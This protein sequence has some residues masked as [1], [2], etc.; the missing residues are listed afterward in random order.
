MTP[1]PLIF[2]PPSRKCTKSLRKSAPSTLPS[3]SVLRLLPPPFFPSPLPSKHRRLMREDLPSQSP[4]RHP[5]LQIVRRIP[6]PQGTCSLFVPNLPTQIF[7]PPLFQTCIKACP[8]SFL[9]APSS[10]PYISL[11]GVSRASCPMNGAPSFPCL[12]E[13]ESSVE[14]CFLIVNLQRTCDRMS[15]FPSCV[16]RRLAFCF[17][18]RVLQ[19]YSHLFLSSPVV[20]NAEVRGPLC[21][22]PAAP[23]M[24][25]FLFSVAAPLHP[26]RIGLE[27][28]LRDRCSCTWCEIFE[29]HPFPGS[30]LSVRWIVLHF[31]CI[32]ALR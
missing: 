25:P 15:S 18:V 32:F 11:W 26:S 4:A 5:Q 10:L 7:F 9:W 22:F 29:T 6:C 23:P 31:V 16:V 2:F 12:E 21:S 20:I 8:Y 17:S 13:R 30:L 27:K 3:S 19:V 28:G 24:G 14:S 1:F